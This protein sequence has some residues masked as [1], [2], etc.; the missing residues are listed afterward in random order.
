MLRQGDCALRACSGFLDVDFLQA[1]ISVRRFPD[2]QVQNPGF[3]IGIYIAL[4]RREAQR[5]TTPETAVLAFDQVVV[6]L[7]FFVA[8]VFFAFQ[9]QNAARDRH[10]E[11]FFFHARD[12][13]ADFESGVGLD[14]VNGGKPCGTEVCAIGSLGRGVTCAELI[15]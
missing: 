2:A 11:V 1:L 13:G 7:F 14:N 9:D 6:F 5:D 15:E 3:E 8:C 12:L 4:F 10:V